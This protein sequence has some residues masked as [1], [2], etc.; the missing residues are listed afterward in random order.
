MCS[1]RTTVQQ[2]LPVHVLR[3]MQWSMMGLQ[4]TVISKQWC[5]LWCWADLSSGL[6]CRRDNIQNLMPTTILNVHMNQFG[7][8]QKDEC[9][10]LATFCI[11]LLIREEKSSYPNGHVS[12][13]GIFWTFHKYKCWISGVLNDDFF[14]YFSRGCRVIIQA[15]LD[16]LHAQDK[17]NQ[18][19]RHIP[20]P[21]IV[22]GDSM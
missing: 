21:I 2:E 14:S 19:L 13:I 17:C 1:S 15:Q 12:N 7:H 18:E 3:M 10:T 9:A 4:L 5:A 22:M 20:A 11:K 16:A 6:N 8:F